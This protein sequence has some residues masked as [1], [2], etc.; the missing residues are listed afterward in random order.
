MDNIEAKDLAGF[1]DP[2]ESEIEMVKQLNNS[3]MVGFTLFNLFFLF[4]GGACLIQKGAPIWVYLMGA[5]FVG[6]SIILIISE[7]KGR[8][9]DSAGKFKIT[10][11]TGFEGKIVRNR[12]DGHTTLEHWMRVRDSMGNETDFIKSDNLGV[13]YLVNGNDTVD[14]YVIIKPKS[15]PLVVSVIRVMEETN[16]LD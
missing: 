13:E 14:V 16:I 11:A 4:G 15:R 8:I 3:G 10:T 2:T 5:V 1:R 7:I 9:N 12:H 6:I